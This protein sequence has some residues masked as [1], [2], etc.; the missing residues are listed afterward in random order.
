MMESDLGPF[1]ARERAAAIL[2]ARDLMGRGDWLILDTETTG[3]DGQA[4]VCQ[5]A[6]L[7]AAGYPLLDTLIRPT[8]PIPPEASA[9]HGITDATVC[10]APR[11]DQVGPWILDLVAGRTVVIYNA[12]FDQR[13]LRQSA[14]AVRMPWLL[15]P[16]ICQ[17]AMEQYARCVGEWSNYHQSFRWQK[18]PPV[19]GESAHSAIADCRATLALI[20]RMAE[21]EEGTGD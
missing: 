17:C 10:D 11:F 14:D 20:E 5:I 4:Q 12:A 21:A 16:Q 8:T 7:D 9:I 13:I 2:W 15:L 3:L 18:L 6:V 1:L 19:P